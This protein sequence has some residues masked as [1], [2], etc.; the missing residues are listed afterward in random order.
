[1]ARILA[2]GTHPEVMPVIERLIRSQDGWEPVVACCA[3]EALEALHVD[4]CVDVLLVG[5][6][7]S[8]EE[9]SLLNTAAGAR[10]PKVPVV[11]HYGGGSG[12]LFAEIWGVLGR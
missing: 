7:L 6:G 4:E 3:Q 12:L 2:V 5:A 9:E 8:P 1:M 11:A 10:T